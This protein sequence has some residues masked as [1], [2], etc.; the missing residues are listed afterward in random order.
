MSAWAGPYLVAVLLVVAAGVGKAI[1]PVMTV[2][3]LRGVGVR[4]P[5]SVVRAFGAAEAVLGVA[6]VVTGNR[7]LAIAI[8]IS[9]V[10]FT[11]FVL[12][13]LA[14]RLPIGSCGCFGRAETPPSWLHVVVNAGAILSAIAVA[15]AAGDG[16]SV[17]HGF[18]DQPLGGVPF[19]LLS[20]V[21]A[22]AA[23]VLLTVVPQVSRRRL[24][25]G[26]S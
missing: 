10:G 23:F 24:A 12:V 6:A 14:R 20:V 25:Q 13:A 5:A 1:D 3:A 16:R 18:S 17:L 9:Y 7:W 21:G 11:V 22:Y 2:G 8:A 15:V 4:L 19:V 26:A